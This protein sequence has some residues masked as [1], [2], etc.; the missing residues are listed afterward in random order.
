MFRKDLEEIIAANP[1]GIAGYFVHY[2]NAGHRFA[3]PAARAAECARTHGRF[4]EFVRLLLEKQDSL[5]IK[6]WG[7]YALEVGLP[8]SA[9]IRACA[10]DSREVPRIA[11]GIALG[12]KRF[13]AGTPTILINGWRMQGSPPKSEL[14]RVI[15]ELQKGKLPFGKTAL[16]G[17]SSR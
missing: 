13:V 2:P 8:D 7:S 15:G 11:A 3:L 9:A 6:S 16:L 12:Q 5:G 1:K 17:V 4:R 10:L 14:E